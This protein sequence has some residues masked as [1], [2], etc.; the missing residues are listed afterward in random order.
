MNDRPK[1]DLRCPGCQSS[2]AVISLTSGKI[3][4]VKGIDVG[5]SERHKVFSNTI[6]EGCG[7]SWQFTVEIKES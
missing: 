1:L 4:E 2:L 5:S 6:C 7:K 3:M